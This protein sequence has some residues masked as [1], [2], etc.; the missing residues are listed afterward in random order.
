MSGLELS[1]SRGL[2]SFTSLESLV[3][4]VAINGM[5]GVLIAGARV[6]DWVHIRRG[7]D[8]RHLRGKKSDGD[9]DLK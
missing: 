5:D 6:R 1:L 2:D 8:G 9:S 4:L 3:L 7:I